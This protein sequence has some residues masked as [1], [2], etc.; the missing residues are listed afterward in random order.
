MT[1]DEY[2]SA[3][4][5]KSQKDAELARYDELCLMALDFAR[6]NNASELEKMLNAGL[7]VNLKSSKGDTLLMLA[8]YNN[9]LDAVRLLLSRGA[10]VDERNDRGQTPLAGAAFK[11]HLAVVKALVEAGADVNANNGLGATPITFAAMFGQRDVLKYLQ[12][13]NAKMGL[14][15]KFLAFFGRAFAK[16]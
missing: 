12:D 14:F 16:K 1:Y 13:K 3:S 4:T 8:S 9:S 2:K 7:G 11:G 5:S 15:S 10:L 6:H